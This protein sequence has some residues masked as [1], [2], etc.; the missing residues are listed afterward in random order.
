MKNFLFDK[1]FI[2][3]EKCD[4]IQEII[5]QEYDLFF[6]QKEISKVVFDWDYNLE[7]FSE[8]FFKTIKFSEI[9]IDVKIV[10]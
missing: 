5:F 9:G 7:S 1:L 8:L 10:F 4:L 2:F 3:V 6:F